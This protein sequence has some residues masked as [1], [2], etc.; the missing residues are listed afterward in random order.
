MITFTLSLPELIECLDQL[1][2]FKPLYASIEIEDN[3][4]K[5]SHKEGEF[6]EG[7]FIYGVYTQIELSQSY[8]KCYFFMPCNEMFLKFLQMKNKI[9]GTRSIN[10]KVDRLEDGY[11]EVVITFQDSTIF[12]YVDD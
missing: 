6:T 9:N 1:I 7:S 2:I 4:M 5:I 3:I 10:I 11:N 12:S 8:D